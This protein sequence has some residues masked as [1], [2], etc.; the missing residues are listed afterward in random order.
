MNLTLGHQHYL[1]AYD[2]STMPDVDSMTEEEFA[3]YL[4][5]CADDGYEEPPE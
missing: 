5:E 3:R 1:E 4:N 2:L